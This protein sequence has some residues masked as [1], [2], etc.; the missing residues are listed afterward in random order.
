MF[1]IDFFYELIVTKKLVTA[2][3]L[4]KIMQEQ[5]ETL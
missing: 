2:D 1:T 3:R 4:A 5:E